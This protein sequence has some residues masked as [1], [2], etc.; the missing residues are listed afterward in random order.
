MPTQFSVYRNPGRNKPAIPF[1]VVAQ[2]NDFRSSA[3]RVVVPLVSLDEFPLS[4]REV[5]P[6][7]TIGDAKVAFSPLQITNV[8]CDILA[9]PVA[10]LA[11]YAV[12]ATAAM[13]AMFSTVWLRP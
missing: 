13:D 3:S 9:D 4:D 12:R 7:F 5:S 8:P 2:A 10:S 6:H 11:G 1:V